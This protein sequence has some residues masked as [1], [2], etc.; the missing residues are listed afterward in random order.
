MLLLHTTSKFMLQINRTCIDWQRTPSL[1]HIGQRRCPVTTSCSRHLPWK[2]WEQR[3]HAASLRS[4]V[5]WQMAHNF[6]ATATATANLFTRFAGRSPP[7]EYSS[8]H[9]GTGR[10]CSLERRPWA[11][12]PSLAPAPQAPRACVPRA[13]AYG[14]RS[15]ARPRR[16]WPRRAWP[17]PGAPRRVS[18]TAS[19]WSCK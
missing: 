5:S 16:R 6:P 2:T 15:G 4:S 3:G 18:T 13:P 19:A 12:R 10:R 9:T 8:Q 11:T 7:P 14:P 1:L 17:A